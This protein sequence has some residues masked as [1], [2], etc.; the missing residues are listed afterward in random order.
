MKNKPASAGSWEIGRAE[1][2]GISARF[3][4]RKMTVLFFNEA[5][6]LGLKETGST[7]FFQSQPQQDLHG[8]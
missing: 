5:L 1:V 2:L 7:S 8:S 4:I 3:L 6:W